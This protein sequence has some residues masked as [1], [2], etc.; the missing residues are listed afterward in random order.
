M[1][2][3]ISTHSLAN[4]TSTHVQTQCPNG[5]R[6]KCGIAWTPLEMHTMF[7][8]SENPIAIHKRGGC[9]ILAVRVKLMT[10][11]PVQFTAKSQLFNF[12]QWWGVFRL[13]LTRSSP[14]T[15]ARESSSAEIWRTEFA[16]RVDR[17]CIYDSTWKQRSIFAVKR[18]AN[19]NRKTGTLTVRRTNSS[20]RRAQRQGRHVPRALARDS[21]AFDR[22]HKK[23]TP[24]SFVLDFVSIP[25]N[26]DYTQRVP[27]GMIGKYSTDRI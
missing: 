26:S 19:F 18:M 3:L 10:S 13:A 25:M 24:T 21:I 22:V 14:S 23:T 8:S 17:P 1:E 16:I 15:S 20:E 27:L 11:I 7:W 4:H 6:T 9:L 12:V 2:I 5:A